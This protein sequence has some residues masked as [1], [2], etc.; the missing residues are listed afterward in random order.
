[1]TTSA[2][3]GVRVI[4][5]SEV[6]AGPFGGCLLGDLG[7]D[8]IKVESYPRVPATRP[9]QV[10]DWRVAPGEGPPYERSWAQHQANRNKRNVALDVRTPAGA[11]LMRRLLREADIV[12]DSFS[13]GTMEKL[14]LGWAELHALNPRLTGISLPGWGV[15]GPYRGYVS[16][17]VGFDCVTGHSYVRGHPW[18][19]EED[20][21]GSTHSDATVPLSIVFA[22]VAALRL[23][24]RSGEGSFVDLSQVEQ[25]AAQLPWAYA[26]WALNHREPPRVG[27]GDPHVVPHGCYAAGGD[28]EWVVLI[29]EDDE[30][31][32]A[33]AG[34]AGHPEWTAD[35]H[36]WASIA[37]RIRERAAVDEAVAAYARTASR[38]ELVEAV[39]AAGA[40]AAPVA[41]PQDQLLSPQLAER[42]WL[43]TVDHPFTG[44]R[45][46]P[47][48]LWQLAPDAPSWDRPCG[49][50]GEHNVEVLR[51]HGYGDDEIEQLAADGVIGTSYGD[52]PPRAA[53]PAG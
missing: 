53:Q 11:E 24:D 35:G 21:P 50:V 32:A 8:V 6:W 20:S 42:G 30:Q 33:L 14:G 1:M 25:L 49:L 45:I 5:L 48:F 40:V 18:R 34:A 47:G 29:A 3:A 17:G 19:R 2:L 13:S 41:D 39:Q 26:E 38:D 36:A 23:R 9:V 52:F 44:P 51:E 7:A 46:Q 37:G 10:P 12:I 27:D 15:A 4:E 31:W 28:D 22:T 16:F 43:E